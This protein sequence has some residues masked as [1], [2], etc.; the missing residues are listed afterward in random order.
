MALLMSSERLGYAGS[1]E[2]RVVWRERELGR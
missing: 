2:R 1:V